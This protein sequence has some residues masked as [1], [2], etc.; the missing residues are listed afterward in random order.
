M[1]ARRYHIYIVSVPFPATAARVPTPIWCPWEMAPFG[2][3]VANPSDLKHAG[4]LL[5]CSDGLGVVILAHAHR[6]DEFYRLY[7]TTQSGSERRLVN[8]RVLPYC[9]CSRP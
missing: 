7:G 2:E 4:E 3:I 1:M 8:R 5:R 9:R 6:W